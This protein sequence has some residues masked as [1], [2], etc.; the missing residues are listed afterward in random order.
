MRSF[1]AHQVPSYQHVS[2]VVEESARHRYQDPWALRATVEGL[3]HVRETCDSVID[4]IA[5]VAHDSTVGWHTRAAALRAL[6][7]IDTER[8]RALLQGVCERGRDAPLMLLAWLARQSSNSENRQTMDPHVSQFFGRISK[9]IATPPT[10]QDIL[11]AALVELSEPI[12]RVRCQQLRRSNRR[13]HII[14]NVRSIVDAAELPIWVREQALRILGKTL[15]PEAVEPLLQYLNDDPLSLGS[16]A[17]WSLGELLCTLDW[18]LDSPAESYISHHFGDNWDPMRVR[19]VA[20]RI[21]EA[22]VDHFSRAESAA[23]RRTLVWA[24]GAAGRPA[25]DHMVER[26]ATDNDPW[27]VHSASAAKKWRQSPYHQQRR[28]RS[29]QR[30]RNT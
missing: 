15:L 9:I 26:A 14:N 4:A 7:D 13:E 29:V 25:F 24:G 21:D 18:Y 28:F 17:V 23:L 20:E 2:A 27:V 1:L 6:G 5:C 30:P 22:L 10:Q 16:P 19:D 12:F 11:L 3:G 8:S